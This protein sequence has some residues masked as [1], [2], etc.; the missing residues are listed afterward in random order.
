MQGVHDTDVIAN[1]SATQMGVLLTFVPPARSYILDQYA[2]TRFRKSFL[3]VIKVLNSDVPEQM[4]NKM[5]NV[6]MTLPYM[7]LQFDGDR[8]DKRQCDK[9]IDIVMNDQTDLITVEGF[10]KKTVRK[11][12]MLDRKYDFGRCHKEA[13]R[14]VQHGD[15]GKAIHLVYL[16]QAMAM[17]VACCVRKFR[18]VSILLDMEVRG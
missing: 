2:L 1:L 17:A 13:D 9:F 10:K 5:S 12:Q 14:N 18:S 7:Y 15:F 4:K 6:M 16:R 8:A 11:K 3:K